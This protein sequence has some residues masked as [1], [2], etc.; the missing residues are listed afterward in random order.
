MLYKL[1]SFLKLFGLYTLN[2]YCSYRVFRFFREFLYLSLYFQS[3]KC[4]CKS[5]Y[6]MYF[7]WDICYFCDNHKMWLIQLNKKDVLFKCM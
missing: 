5:N 1:G 2:T 4:L 7:N 6:S 3:Q